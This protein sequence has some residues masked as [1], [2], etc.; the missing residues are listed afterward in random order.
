MSDQDSSPDATR[1]GTAAVENQLSAAVDS[2]HQKVVESIGPA[3]EGIQTF[4]EQQKNLGAV[5][6]GSAARAIHS[7][8]RE[9]E[10]ELP[11]IAKSIHEA[12]A[13]L[14]GASSSMRQQTPEKIVETVGR[15][16]R[17][18]P[19]AFFGGAVLAGFALSRFLKSSAERGGA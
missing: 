7:A 8:A 15:F 2:A 16:A 19:A 13:K 9:F 17:E 5:Q 14:E 18:R 11:G 1:G 10:T 12:A 3:K 6:I 4:V